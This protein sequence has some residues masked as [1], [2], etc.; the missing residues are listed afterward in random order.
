MSDVAVVEG[1]GEV[2]GAKLKAVGIGTTK[3]LLV[4]GA[5]RAGRQKIENDSGI[6]GALILRWVNHLDL[7][8]IRGVAA[9][10]AELLE[11]SGVDSVPELS[12]R[13]AANLHAKMVEVN[14]HKKLVRKLPTL[15][16]VADWV[17]QAKELPKV[18]TH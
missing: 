12:H 4:R 8:R 16:Q 11:A 14:A 3:K 13:I 15:N 10:Y 9:Q 2:Y 5:S 1:I 17:Q 6:G 7:F 18:V